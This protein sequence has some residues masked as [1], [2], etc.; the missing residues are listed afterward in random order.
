[1]YYMIFHSGYSHNILLVIIN[2]LYYCSFILS[3]ARLLI[4]DPEFAC[5]DPGHETSHD[6]EYLGHLAELQFKSI[7]PSEACEDPLA[8]FYCIFCCIN[9]DSVYIG[10]L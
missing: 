2:I 5:S 1:M 9:L 4:D 3:L 8:F 10:Y 7:C 6:Q